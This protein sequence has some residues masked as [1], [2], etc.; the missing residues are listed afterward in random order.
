LFQLFR[1]GSALANPGAIQ[2]GTVLAVVIVA[3][4]EVSKA[5]GG[6]LPIDEHTAQAIADGVAAFA[7][8]VIA[9]TS[10]HVGLPAKPTSG[11]D[12]TGTG[13][14]DPKPQPQDRKQAGYTGAP[15]PNLP[16]AD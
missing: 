1:K 2:N 3:I 10:P 5:F 15:F 12:D 8:V 4:S 13:S 14:S 9:I 6:P 7:G 16:G 11:L